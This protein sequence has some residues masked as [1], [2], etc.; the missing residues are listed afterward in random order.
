MSL[1]TGQVPV[2]GDETPDCE[3]FGL[4]RFIEELRGAGELEV[5]ADLTHLA[6]V[7]GHVDGNPK[8]VLFEH[9]GAQGVALTANIMGSR[10]RMARAFGVEPKLLLQEIQRRLRTP[11][12]VVEV[13]REQAPAQQVVLTGDAIDLT[14]LP[15]H[16][17]HQHD[18]APYIS[19]AMDFA[20]DAAA[21]WT[22]VGLRR[23]M[24]RGRAETGIDLMAPSD[25]RAIFLA[26]VARGE[27][28]PLSIVVGAHPV[29]YLAA[30]MR[31]PVDELRLIAAMRGQTLP[32]VKSVTNDLLVPAD[33]EYV[34]EGYL[35]AKG[36]VESE[37]PYGEFLGY[38]GEVKRNPV[39]RVTAI[40]HRRNPVFQTISISGRALGRTDTAL[41]C[42]LRTEVLAWRALEVAVR[43]PLAVYAPPASGGVYNLRVSLRQRVPGEA[44]NAIAALFSSVANIKNVFV[45]DPDIDIFSDE[46]MEWALATRFQPTR[47]LVVGD[48]FRTL[49][50]DPSLDGAVTGS[51]AGYDMTLP[52]G[53][54]GLA[55][56]VPETPTYTGARF[57]SLREALA[58][59]PKSFVQLMAAVDSRDGREI[60]VTLE[61]LRNEGVLSRDEEGRY[62]LRGA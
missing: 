54:T 4:G 56:E 61:E 46:Q 51:K 16:L 11:Q 18:G 24:L 22:N 14:T 40:T 53:A 48:G 25:L 10:A 37:G 52:F 49:P 34:I 55:S 45:V 29:D 28:L 33:A 23:L 8:A 20:R 57:A 5:H 27:H 3:A 35:D 26:S 60:V 39:F 47:D 9:A 36:Y 43:E 30:T 19:A 38:Y 31:L 6:D 21:G 41:L 50:L 32:V 17:Q 7:A 13:S 44:R 58:D 42:S 15:I 59:G 2:N 12:R 62:V 1:E